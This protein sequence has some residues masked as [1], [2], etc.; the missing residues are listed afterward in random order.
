MCYHRSVNNK[1]V[2]MTR[3]LHIV[4]SDSG[5]AFE[6][7]LDKDRSV[8]MHVKNVQSLSIETFKISTN[9]SVPTVKKFLKNV[10]TL[11]TY[12]NHQNFFRP[13]VHS[14]FH[15]QKSIS[16]LGPKMRDMILAEIKYLTTVSAL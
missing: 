16:Y 6:D 7:L 8:P 10:I 15:G 2:C 11:I 14:V 12:E 13:K 1:I 5:S 3:C 9:L 4:Y